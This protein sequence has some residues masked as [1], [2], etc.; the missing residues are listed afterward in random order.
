[1]RMT[2]HK[3]DQG[4]PSRQIARIETSVMNLSASCHPVRKRIVEE[5]KGLAFPY[6]S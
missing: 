6:I 2:G 5:I 3:R 4:A 1:M